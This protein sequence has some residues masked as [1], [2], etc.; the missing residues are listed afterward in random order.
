MMS[1]GHNVSHQALPANT[2]FTLGFLS[3]LTA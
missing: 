1:Y 3:S 2:Q